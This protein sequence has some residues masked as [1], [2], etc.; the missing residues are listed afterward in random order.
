MWASHGDF[1]AA[2][3]PGFRRGRHERERAGRGDGR[4]AAASCTRCCSIPEVAHTD[5]GTEILRNFAFT[6]SAAA[7]ATGRWPR[8]STR[9]SA[10]SGSRSATAGWSARSE[11]RRGFDGG[12][13]ADAPGHRRSADLHLRGQ[14][15]AAARRG[16]AGAAA[17]RRR[18]RLPLVFVD[19]SRL[20]LDRLRGR[21]RSGAEAQDHRRDLHRGVRGARR[22][23]LGRLRFPGAGHALSRRDR[24]GLGR[25]AVGTRSRATTTS[26]ACPSACGSSWSS[27][28]ASCSR[29]RCGRSAGTSGLDE[30]FVVRQPFPG[31]GLAVRILGEVTRERLDAAARAPTRSWSTKSGSAGWYRAALAELR[32]AA[33]GAERRRDGRRA[34]LRVHGRRSAPSRAA[35]A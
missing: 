28:C 13:A 16:R 34:D 26:A 5:R 10:A 7:R 14:R 6:A 20:F 12:G 25:G 9:R 17:L 29:T 8:S 11:R 24:V 32:R 4:S 31:P 15:P 30:E 35:T 2:P 33:A 22:R 19:A 21:D 23:E 27:R 1:V 3:P 18:L